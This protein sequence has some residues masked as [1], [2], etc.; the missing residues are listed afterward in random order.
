MLNQDD[1][2]AVIGGCRLPSA[3]QAYVD[4]TR[5]SEP[6][7]LVGGGNFR[8]TPIRFA[9]QRMGRVIQAESDTVEGAFVR[10]CEFDDR[11]VLEFWDQPPSVPLVIINKRG[12]R[13]RT[14]YTPDFLV[15]RPQG[16]TVV[17]CKSLA[18][19]GR[20]IA[21]RPQDWI[22]IESGYRYRPAYEYFAELGVLHEVWAPDARSALRSS[23]I[24]LLLAA[25]R[26]PAPSKEIKLRTRICTYL[27]N[28][29]IASISQLC[30]ALKLPDS[31]ML[32]RGISQGWL[33]APLD[34]YLLSKPED[35]LIALNPVQYDLAIEALALC[36][37]APVIGMIA[38]QT[39]VP[40]PAQAVVMLQRQQELLGQ[41]PPSVTA[42]TLRRHRARLRSMQ[43]DIRA[44]LPLRRSG[45]RKPRLTAQH[46][47]FLQASITKHHAT[48][49]A[50]SAPASHLRYENDFI[51]AKAKGDFQPHEFA[52]SLNTFLDRIAK[53]DAEDLD[54]ARGG[55]R[56]ANAVAAPVDREFN[57]APASRPFQIAHAD[58]YLADKWLSVRLSG[59]RVFSRKPWVSVLRD[60]IR[61]VLA[62]TVGFRAPSRKVLAELLRDC[63]RRH[64]RLPEVIVSDCG[65]DFQSV[66]YESTLAILGV[67]KK[68][69]PSA[70]PR[71]GGSLERWFGTFK[72]QILWSSPGSTRNDGKGRTVSPSHRGH[73][74]A[75]QDLIDF[76]HEL[77]SVIFGQINLHLRAEQLN[78]PDAVTAAELAMYPMSGIPVEYD[79]RFMV[80]TSVA[81]DE[82]KYKVDRS[83]GINPLG[84]W[85]WHPALARMAHKRVEVR[86][87]PWDEDLV[88]A[89][90][91]NDWVCCRARGTLYQESKDL[92]AMI[93][94]ATLRLDGRQELAEAKHEADLALSRH[95]S[96]RDRTPPSDA[97]ADDPETQDDLSG[98]PPTSLDDIS[99]IPVNWSL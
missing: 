87:D 82:E 42:R 27:V 17:E 3:G 47:A 91:D 50:L 51:D 61:E 49:T 98:T 86:L 37:S 90:V 44:L 41:C 84:R 6:S 79:Q 15:I 22:T 72:T 40:G 89:L 67:H 21:D 43:G 36:H 26:A 38:V 60:D 25:R 80:A 55:N 11:N 4:A 32:L 24:D 78:S 70:A 75:E 30:R 1:Y 99:P 81:A 28:T 34:Q 63:G 53:R 13:Q 33:Y 39:A 68:D 16:P 77:E 62:L 45:N 96:N 65:S 83:R 5:N 93:C 73:R 95:L 88:Y 2:R 9:S 74:L 19:L 7:R 12:H 23:N 35:A 92:V 94:R 59:G 18:E 71:F 14:T 64:G 76:Y 56:A 54:R 69:R 85:Y 48:G 29:P 31:T 52:V 58:H 20:L 10:L 46:E 66:F 57:S 8:N 97:P